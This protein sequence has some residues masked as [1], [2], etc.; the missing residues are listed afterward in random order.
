MLIRDLDRIASCFKHSTH[1]AIVMDDDRPT[2]AS[3]GPEPCVPP[4]L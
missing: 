2:V 3:R 1:H 4:G